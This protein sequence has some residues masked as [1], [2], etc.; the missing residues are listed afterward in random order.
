MPQWR[1]W[2][3]LALDLIVPENRRVYGCGQGCFLVSPAISYLLLQS[4]AVLT[5]HPPLCP[6]LNSVQCNLGESLCTLVFA[7]GTFPYALRTVAIPWSLDQDRS[8]ASCFGEVLWSCAK[9][10][11]LGD[12]NFLSLTF[13]W[14]SSRQMKKRSMSTL[15]SAS[16]TCGSFRYCGSVLPQCAIFCRRL[17]SLRN[18][19]LRLMS[20]QLMS[21]TAFK[22]RD[23]FAQLLLR[24][25]SA[26]LMSLTT[27][28][29]IDTIAR[30]VHVIAETCQMTMNYVPFLRW[31]R[32]FSTQKKYDF[33]DQSGPY[34]DRKTWTLIEGTR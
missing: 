16:S 23:V 5:A 19:L 33:N 29:S 3:L 22:T 8:W 28:T 30:K 15:S 32:L 14:S 10:F 25:M 26:Q 31:A 1:N 21:L 27:S 6:L 9:C 34:W 11:R 20:A 4:K 18:Y 12:G 24:M 7:I 2:F 17:I 13:F